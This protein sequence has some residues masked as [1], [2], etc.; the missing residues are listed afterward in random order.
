MS[1]EIRNILQIEEGLHTRRETEII[2][3]ITEAKAAI[4]QTEQV[5]VVPVSNVAK[6]ATSPEN[7]LKQV[8]VEIGNVSTVVKRATCPANAQMRESLALAEAEVGAVVPALIAAK[9]AISQE[10][11]PMNE[12]L[13][14]D[15]V[16]VVVELALIAAKKAISQESAQ[17]PEL[18]TIAVKAEV[19]AAEIS[20]LLIL[21]EMTQLCKNQ[22]Q[23]DGP[24]VMQQEAEKNG[25]ALVEPQ[26]GTQLHR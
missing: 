20:N 18:R 4:K 15:V 5:V 6:K 9:K 25:E 7:V 8:V 11:A 22:Q 24:L 13:V 1:S 19:E 26:I 10:S 16:A 2:V 3:K 12:S 21:E 17:I 14:L 23:V